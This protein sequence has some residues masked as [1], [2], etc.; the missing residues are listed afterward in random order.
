MVLVEITDELRSVVCDWMLTKLHDDKLLCNF[1]QQSMVDFDDEESYVNS[2]KAN[3]SPMGIECFYALANKFSRPIWIQ[4]PSGEILKN[5]EKF[6]GE[7]IL[8]D[9]DGKVYHILDI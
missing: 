5:F 7:P 1:V 6:C 3:K 8:V 4:H 9:Y 2:K